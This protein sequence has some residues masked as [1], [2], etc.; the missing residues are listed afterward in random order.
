MRRL[1]S[2]FGRADRSTSEWAAEH[3]TFTMLARDTR[4]KEPA[5]AISLEAPSSARRSEEGEPLSKRDD[6]PTSGCCS[7]SHDAQWRMR[8]GWAALVP[9][10]SGEA[11]QRQPHARGVGMFLVHCCAHAG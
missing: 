9:E 2:G 10:A 6:C 5:C 8:A 7:G 3:C 4:P 1:N 11:E